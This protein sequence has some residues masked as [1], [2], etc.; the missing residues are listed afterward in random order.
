MSSV[1]DESPI[2]PVTPLTLPH[3]PPTPPPLPKFTNNKRS[4]GTSEPSNILKYGQLADGYSFR[5]AII[6]KQSQLL[7][8]RRSIDEQVRKQKEENTGMS[9]SSKCIKMVG[10]PEYQLD[11]GSTGK[12]RKPFA[13]CATL[14]DPN[15]RGKLDLTEVKSAAMRRRL[16]ANLASSEDDQETIISYETHTVEPRDDIETEKWRV[17][18][19]EPIAE[20]EY[21]DYNKTTFKND[22]PISIV[23]H[24]AKPLLFE[25]PK[26]LYTGTRKF[27]PLDRMDSIERLNLEL[28]GSL[29]SLSKMI[30]SIGNHSRP[31]SVATNSQKSSPESLTR[32]YGLVGKTQTKPLGAR[33]DRESNGFYNG[34]R[35]HIH[36]ER[37]CQRV[38][39]GDLLLDPSSTHYIAS[40]DYDQFIL[41]SSSRARMGTR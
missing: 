17:I 25:H 16:L 36:D 33:F 5:D 31:D 29:D 19:H 13:Y 14:N 28:T 6:S 37:S 10:Y 27:Q 26:E 38:S 15:N 4:S 2:S 35:D 23:R 18:Y 8:N 30:S 41:G 34:T 24:D 40:P 1:V 20:S 22:K 9:D 7:M 3:S 39:I 12:D 11:H 21:I 32:D